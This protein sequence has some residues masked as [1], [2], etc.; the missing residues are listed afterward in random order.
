MK[1]TLKKYKNKNIKKTKTKNYNT[2]SSKKKNFIKAIL[3]EWK[4]LTGG[5]C[6]KDT[7]T[8]YKNDYYLSFNKIGDFNNHIHL[9][10]KNLNDIKYVMKKMDMK[11]NK[12]VHSQ[13]IKINTL[14][15][16]KKIVRSMIA[17]YKDFSKK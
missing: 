1:K 13:E 16:P 12:I 4:T 17:N 3:N 5:Y 9:I 14:S 2:T 11:E 8:I 15:D 6:E 10:L 7:M